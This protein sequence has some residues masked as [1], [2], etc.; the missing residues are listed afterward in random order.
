MTENENVVYSSGVIDFVA[1]A[2]DFCSFL[3]N[4]SYPS[5]LE[6]L[7]KI[8]KILPVL[9]FR[10]SLLPENEL[11]GDEETESFVKEEDYSRVVALISNLMGEEDVYLDVF[12][13]DM[14][15]SDT[16]ISSFVSED[17]ADIYQDVRN[18]ITIYQYNLSDQMN[19]ALFMC[20]ENF[21]IYWGQKLVNV[22]RPLHSLFYA[23]NELEDE[24]ID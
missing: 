5:R 18:F 17:I 4:D 9:Y 15:Y 21:R 12:I 3:E 22:I 2:V 10:A 24:E 6:F 11:I 20:R 19:N 23:V 8:L 7:E 16:P 1:T 14:K 13:E